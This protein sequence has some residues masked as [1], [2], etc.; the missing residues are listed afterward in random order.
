MRV[1]CTDLHEKHT[2]SVEFRGT[3]PGMVP[4]PEA[5]GRVGS[6]L[7]RLSACDFVELTPPE[8]VSGETLAALSRVHETGMLEFLKDCAEHARRTAR[9]VIADSFALRRLARR[10]QSLSARL[11][12]YCSDAQS[13]VTGGT[14]DA[15]LGAASCALTGAKNLVGGE[16][17]AYAL[18]RPP[19][20]HAGTDYFGG[21]C[22][23]NNAALAGFALSDYGRVAVLD[24]DYHHGNGTQDIFYDSDRVS[25]VSVH[26][27]PAVAYPY[28][29]GYADEFGE[30]RGRGYNRNFP[31][32]QDADERV[33]LETFGRA[34]DVLGSLN[35]ELIVVSLGTDTAAGDPIGD[36]GLSLQAFGEMGRQVGDLHRPTLVIQEG[37]YAIGTAGECVCGFLG[38]VGGFTDPEASAASDDRY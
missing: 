24:I 6:I 3:V 21:Y 36:L 22:Y 15:A 31:V 7:C 33:Y 23:L 13:P 12:Y 18:C 9:D 16:R 27:D 26:A 34:L 25:F 4:H 10:P 1:I 8:V 32:A 19:G 29:I 11:G 37:G 17:L 5:S 20:H 30:G 14:W 35:P 2:P 38:S 28:Y